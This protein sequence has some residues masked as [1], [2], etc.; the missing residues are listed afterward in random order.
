MANR[1]FLTP[2]QVT[3]RIQIDERIVTRWLRDGYLRG[4]RLGRNWRIAPEDLESFM[5]SHANRSK[6]DL[7]SSPSRPRR[8]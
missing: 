3:E 5:E 2:A 6:D 1:V 8:L 7:K 4:Y